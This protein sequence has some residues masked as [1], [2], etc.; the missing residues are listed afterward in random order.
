MRAAAARIPVASGT[1]ATGE[2]GASLTQPYIMFFLSI[3]LFWR[4]TLVPH[5]L[6]ILKIGSIFLAQLQGGWTAKQ[7]D[8]NWKGRELLRKFHRKM[9]SIVVDRRRRNGSDGSDGVVT[10]TG[11]AV[12]HSELKFDWKSLNWRERAKEERNRTG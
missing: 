9:S 1:T 7:K 5:I 2:F 4:L 11:E 6:E 8:K 3:R 10:R 12:T